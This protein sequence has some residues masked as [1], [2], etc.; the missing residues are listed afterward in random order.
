M[1]IEIKLDIPPD[2]TFLSSLLYEGILYLANVGVLEEK[3]HQNL[4]K[5]SDDAFIKAFES[6]TENTNRNRVEG[7]SIVM[8]GNDNLNKKL[9]N[10][11]KIGSASK[12]S[13]RDILIL[14]S[15]ENGKL[16]VC[17]Q[18][19]EI[20]LEEKG[21]KIYLGSGAKQDR[22]TAQLFKVDRYT[23]FSSLETSYTS[24]QL[25]MYLSKEVVLLM[26]LGVYSSFIT[27]IRTE[28]G[29]SHFFCFFSSDEIQKLLM[30]GKGDLIKKYTD[31]KVAI[32]ENFS[33]IL[34]SRI[35]EVLLVELSTNISLIEKMIEGNIDKLS[36]LLFKVN[37]E[38]QT[39]KIYEKIPLTVY[40]NPVFLKILERF[41]KPSDR[42]V[43][44][45]N[46]AL[47]PNSVMFKALATP[48][49]PE[50]ENVLKAVLGLHK[51]ITAEDAQGWFIFLREL[52]NATLKCERESDR[53]DYNFILSGM[54]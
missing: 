19:V 5:V 24:T 37:P 31:I 52:V 11:F 41:G 42:I 51:F 49:R 20:N 13:F 28:G 30:K 4:I 43:R 45:L 25:T 6:L 17:R 40:E 34:R 15:S 36:L 18:K 21:R 9:P 47:K 44:R 22:L 26:L 53:R 29:I 10:L 46:D 7:I 33:K 8:S 14:L 48:T 23:G 16:G 2:S 38:G 32:Q 27:T 35:N 3:I 39:Y 54:V 12:K 1:P 50:H